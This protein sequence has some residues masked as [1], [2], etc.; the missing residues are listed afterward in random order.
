MVTSLVIRIWMFQLEK[1]PKLNHLPRTVN[2]KASHVVKA[3]GNETGA[4]QVTVASKLLGDRRLLYKKCR[5]CI[6]EEC[7]I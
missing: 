6:L 3:L 1:L 4:V 7:A 2:Q 5:A